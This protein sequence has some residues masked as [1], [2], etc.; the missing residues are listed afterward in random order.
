MGRRC[1][2]CASKFTVAGL[3]EALKGEVKPFGIEVHCIEPG[4]FA[5]FL[6]SA[7]N[8]ALNKSASI[9]DYESLN[10]MFE[11]AFQATSG[12]QHGDP[13]K[14]VRRMIESVTHTGY[15]EGKEVPTRVVLGKDAYGRSGKVIERMQKEREEWK[16]WTEDSWR[17]DID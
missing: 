2:S 9:K 6:L 1:W 14:G 10:K 12:N 13:V 11:E 15:A 17:D 7:S 5:T 8:L 4:Y 16:E 3:S